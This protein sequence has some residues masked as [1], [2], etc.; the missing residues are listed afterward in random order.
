MIASITRFF[1]SLPPEAQEKVGFCPLKE[2]GVSKIVLTGSGGPFR[3]TPLNEFEHITPAQAVAHPK[4][5]QMGKKNL[6]G[7]CH[8][9]EIKG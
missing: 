7:F 5:G 2:L 9:D 4:T 3:Y 6:R 1:E 8:D